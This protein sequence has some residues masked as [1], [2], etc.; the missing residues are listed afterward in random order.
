MWFISEHNY[1][2]I[3]DLQSRERKPQQVSNHYEIDS[4]VSGQELQRLSSLLAMIAN[5]AVQTSTR[6]LLTNANFFKDTPTMLD[7]TKH[8][9]IDR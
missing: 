1:S 5:M 2:I 4:L 8:Q 9:P 6:T 3:T 7:T